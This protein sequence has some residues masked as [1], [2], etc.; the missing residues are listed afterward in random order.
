VFAVVIYY[1]HYKHSI[2]AK[3]NDDTEKEENV[4]EVFSSAA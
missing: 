1:E 3:D 2:P 4:I